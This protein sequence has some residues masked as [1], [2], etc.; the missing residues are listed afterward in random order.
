[1]VKFAGAV[2][3]AIATIFGGCEPAFA[4][5]NGIFAL[6]AGLAS[7]AAQ[8]TDS[9]HPN[10]PEDRRD[11]VY[12]P[13][14]TESPKPLLKKLVGN[15]LLDQKDIW[16]SPFHMHGTDA[17]W[18]IGFGGLTA[19]LVAT[20]H[21]TST[22]F[23]NS[24]GQVAWA[25]NI[26]NIGSAYT[27]A[28]AAA[29]FYAFGALD[30][31]PKAREVGI[32][33][34][35]AMLDSLIVVSVLKPVAGRNRPNNATE[36]GEFFDAGASFPSGHA[37]S[38]WALASVISYEYGHTKIVP[39]I[40]CSLAALVSVARFGAQQHYASDLVAGGA[41]G[42]FIGRYVWKTHQ[43]HALH[44]H[45]GLKAFILPQIVPGS[46]TYAVAVTL[47]K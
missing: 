31:D 23:E 19:A 37:I 27:L 2:A 34:G 26:S 39:I 45:G 16:T 20:D 18:W 7:A 30:N 41:M 33:G 38:S 24:K 12:Y 25:N 4:Q 47:Q 36:P 40:A 35:E 29:G 15:V 17:L 42:W 44:P 43:D 28:S 6:G 21:Q 14:D 5:D 3:V 11:R 1:M 13:G 22:V 9:D 8:I 32:L 46:G 10:V